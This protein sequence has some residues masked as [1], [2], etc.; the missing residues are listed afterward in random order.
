MTRYTLEHEDGQFRWWRRV[1]S[2]GW[3]LDEPCGLFKDMES[4]R[5]M[6]GLLK[7]VP[8][9]KRKYPDAIEEYR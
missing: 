7:K 6:R 5:K 8:D 4:A 1:R 2:Y 3:R 9:S